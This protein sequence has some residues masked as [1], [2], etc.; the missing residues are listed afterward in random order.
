MYG[1][2]GKCWELWKMEKL[3]SKI[4]ERIDISI[5]TVGVIRT[6][7]TKENGKTS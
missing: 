6:M 2:Y 5:G 4:D 7:G 3:L 1:N